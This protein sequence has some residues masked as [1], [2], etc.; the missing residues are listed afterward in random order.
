M[1]QVQAGY[2]L[3]TCGGSK[4]T[5]ALVRLDDLAGAWG[6]EQNRIYYYIT[7]TQYVN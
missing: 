2:L 6:T 4:Q 7:K 5:Q 1:L 3:I